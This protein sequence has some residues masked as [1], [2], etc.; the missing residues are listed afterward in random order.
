[1]EP[2]MRLRTDFALFVALC[3]CLGPA[4]PPSAG[5]ERKAPPP[6]KEEPEKSPFAA[7]QFRYIGPEGN[8]VSSVAGVAG[9]ANIYYAGA[10]SGGIFR[11]T[12]AGVNWEP[13]FDGQPVSSIGALAVAPSDPNVVWAGTGEPFIRS[14]ISIGWGVF[15]STDAGKTWTKAGLETT[16]RIARMVVDPRDPDVALACALGTAYG[17]QPDRGVF[18]TA[19]G[20]KSWTKILFVDEKTGCSDLVMDPNNP[21]IL[22]AGTWQIEIHTYG[23]ESGGPGSG[24]YRS[25]DAGATWKPLEEKGLPK[26]PWGK[27]GLAMSKANSNRVYA[28]IEV[29][30]GVPWKGQ[31]NEG[32]RLWRSDDGGEQWQLMTSD[33][34]VAGR[35]HYYNRMGVAPDDPDEAYFLTSAWAKTKDGGKTI[36]DPPPAQVPGGDHH[37][38]WIDS[39]NGS[40]LIVSHDVGVSI[41]LNRGQSWVVT[42]LPVAQMYHVTVDDRIP[43]YV[44]GNRQD[45]PSTR[46]PSNSK[47][48]NPE[49]FPGIPRGMWQSV[50]GGECGWATPDPEDPDII[51]SSASGYGSL[52][53]IVTRY[54]LRTNTA[55]NVE[56]WPQS[57]VGTPAADVK[58]RFLWTFPLTISPH[59]HNKVYVGSQHVHVTTDG[60]NSWQIISPD[61]TLNDKSR[62]QISGGLT[63][64]NIGVEYA[65]VVFAIAESRLE[66]GLIWA[67]TNDGL[68]QLTRD[69]GKNWTSVTSA[70]P[71]LQPW[72]T[73]SHIEPSRYDAGTAYVVVDFHQMDNRDPFVYRTNDYGKTWKAITSGIVRS[74]LSYAHIIREDPVRRG[75]LFLGMENGIYVSFDDG[76]HW[77]PLQSNLPHAP[78]YGLVVQERF[79]DLVVGTYGR[80]FWVLD[81]MT[82]LR[83]L[84]GGAL[85][86]EASLFSPRPAYRLRGVEA[87]FAAWSDPVAGKNPPEGAALHYWLPAAVKEKDEVSGKEKEEISLSVEDASGKV[88]RKF[89]G[90]AKAG[91]NRAYWD[92]AFDKTKEARLRTSPQHASYHKV[93]LEGIPAPGVPRF[94]LLAPPGDYK[95]KLK[96]GDR[97]LVQ[98]LTVL[99]DPNTG[100]SEEDLRAQMALANDLVAD[101]NGVVD[102]INSVE[103]V[104]G[105]LAAL[106]LRFAGDAGPKEV[107]EAA[108]AL[109]KKFVALEERLF[110]VRVTGRG[111]DLLRWPTRLAEQLAYLATVMTSADFAPTAAQREVHELLH[112]QAAEHRKKLDELIARDLA[113]FNAM[114]AEKKLAGVVPLL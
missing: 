106:V 19:D 65:G 33:R 42:Q 99:R 68:V 72:G 8:R 85:P 83:Q 84:P 9:N 70:I 16:G 36:I 69:G 46:G 10:A 94:A 12:D 92:L 5:A 82:L 64:D 76:E 81:D 105:Q 49:G 43:Y 50:G 73:I 78:V 22:F 24:L 59:D 40:R 97:E 66:P 2:S 87:P 96:V 93:P 7:L 31:E 75:L 63:P 110:Q 4:A 37:D 67:G 44:Y 113:A 95:L 60:G 91:L 86:K 26:K 28:L 77:Q 109:D 88:V 57:T 29:G 11:T 56:V 98:P 104:R 89:K 30:D 107:R 1:M 38:I 58:F 48:G 47:L 18:R 61:L 74:P 114:L 3:L 80:G 15:R 62:Q 101:L 52:G 54:D 35:T 32:G 112:G 100:A 17:P 27:V 25:T 45:G 55:R 41:S 103:S 23:R 51:W 39:S 13:V 53:G 102:A 34:Q 90:P 111:Q 71:N 79:G 20:G 6:A 108:E 14:N 21:R